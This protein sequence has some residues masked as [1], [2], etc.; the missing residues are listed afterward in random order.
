[1]LRRL[2][3]QRSDIFNQW[4]APFSG[5]DL[6]QTSS[7][8]VAVTAVAIAIAIGVIYASLQGALSAAV[9][10]IGGRIVSVVTGALS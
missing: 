3:L 7:E 6:G 10:I 5:G 8:Y 2:Y 9:S 1:M 4:A